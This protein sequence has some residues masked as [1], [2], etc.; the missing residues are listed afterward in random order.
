MQIERGLTLEE[1]NGGNIQVPVLYHSNMGPCMGIVP[2][3]PRSLAG[4]RRYLAY[5]SIGAS[6]STDHSPIYT[7]CARLHASPCSRLPACLPEPACRSQ[8]EAD[9]KGLL[10]DKEAESAR[11][12][13]EI[14]RLRAALTHAQALHASQGAEVQ[15]LSQQ[16][17]QTAATS[18]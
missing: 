12:R 16:A 1:S 17:Q 14:S 6:S 7:T 4:W 15:A 3:V 11:L 13:A 8:I 5:R 18:K 10:S 2:L 9:F